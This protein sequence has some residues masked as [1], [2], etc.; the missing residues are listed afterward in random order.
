MWISEH[1]EFIDIKKILFDKFNKENFSLEY[2]NSQDGEI[3]EIY[4][5]MSWEEFKA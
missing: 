2:T 4:D 1:I 3:Y 5:E